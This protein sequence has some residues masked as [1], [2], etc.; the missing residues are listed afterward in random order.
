[1]ISVPLLGD[2]LRSLNLR[3]HNGQIIVRFG[4]PDKVSHF[5]L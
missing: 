1:M 5:G 3:D 2:R 4:L